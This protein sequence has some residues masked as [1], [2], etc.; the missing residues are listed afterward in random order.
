MTIRSIISTI[1]ADTPNSF[2]KERKT[3]WISRCEKQIISEIMLL[4]PAE[5]DDYSWDYDADRELVLP[6]PYT[7]LYA[8]Y[9]AAQMHLAYQEA[10][11]YQNTMQIF[12]TVWDDCCAWYADTYSPA[13]LAPEDRARPVPI[14]TWVQGETITIEFTL[15]YDQSSIAEIVL[16]LIAYNS[17]LVRTSADMEISGSVAR[18][19]LDSSV[20]AGMPTGIWRAVVMVTDTAGVTVHSAQAYTMRLVD[21][22]ARLR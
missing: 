22:R 6:E 10:D 5:Y 21:V 18:L 16:T 3:G 19:T 11:G 2:S 7:Q 4:N 15:P 9:V 20:T 13:N 14:E 1:D 12:N 8:L 17:E